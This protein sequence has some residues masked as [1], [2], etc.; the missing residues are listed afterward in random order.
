MSRPKGMV[1]GFWIVTAL[2]CLQMAFTAYAELAL[3]Q[4][5]QAFVH[6]GFPA[7]FRVELSWAKLLGIVLVLAPVPSRVKEWAYCGFAIDLVSAVI[8]HVA[9]GDGPSAWGWAVVTGALWA[10]S[11]SLWRRLEAR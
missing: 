8:A 2:F 3:P 10:G 11:Y 4:V 9:V 7:Y 1:I 5:A 6:L